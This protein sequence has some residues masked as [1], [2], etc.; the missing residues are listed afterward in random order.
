MPAK[1]KKQTK[2][3][4]WMNSR[5]AMG[6]SGACSNESYVIAQELAENWIT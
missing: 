6:A 3:R 5:K 4:P 2:S 1:T